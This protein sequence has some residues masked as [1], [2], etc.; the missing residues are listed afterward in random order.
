[1]NINIDKQ[2]N[3]FRRL[4]QDDDPRILKEGEYRYAL[5][6]RVGSSEDGN[7]GLVETI[8]GNSLVSVSL[9]SGTNKVIGSCEDRITNSIF[10]FVW[11]SSGYHTIYRYFVSTNTIVQIFQSSILNFQ[12]SN[13]ISAI[14]VDNMLYWVD[15]YNEAR[16]LN[17][18]Q[19]ILGNS[20]ITAH[21]SLFK[22]GPLFP[23]VVTTSTTMAT[24]KNRTDNKS[25]VIAFRYVYNDNEKSVFSPFSKLAVTSYQDNK[26]D[27]ITIDLTGG[28]KNREF[29]DLYGGPIIYLPKY[30]SVIKGIEVVFRDSPTG[31][32]K[33]L[34][35][36]P[37][38][39]ASTYLTTIFG[40]ITFKNDEIYAIIANSETTKQVDAIPKTPHAIS[41]IKGRLFLA[42]YK[43][44]FD[45][46]ALNVTRNT[47]TYTTYSPTDK[48]KMYLKN[49]CK[50][51]YG[52]VF[53]DEYGRRSGVYTNDQ[54]KVSVDNRYSK[55]YITVKFTLVGQPP[56]WAN[57]YE[58]V[59]TDNLTMSWFCQA[60][61]NDIYYNLKSDP[62]TL[63]PTY[64]Y[65]NYVDQQNTTDSDTSY[66]P[67]KR[68]IEMHINIGNFENQNNKVPYTFTEGDHVSILSIGA[69]LIRGVHVYDSSPASENLR[70]LKIKRTYDTQYGKV[71]VVDYDT[72]SPPYI[73]KG[74]I[75]EIY[76][77]RDNSAPVL[78]YEIGESHEIN[79]PGTPS[80][81]FSQTV[82]QLSTGD[83]HYIQKD[84]VVSA[85]LDQA[86]TE[87]P[88][89][90]IQSM[91]PNRDDIL[92]YWESGLGQPSAIL[93]I[94][95]EV[96][97]TTAIR[98]S[99]EYIQGSNINGLSSFEALNE[100]ILPVEYGPICKLQVSSNNTS[101]TNVMLSVHSK[102]VVS[103]YINEAIFTDVAGKNIVSVTDSVMPSSM[104]MQGSYG[105]VNPESIIQQDSRV[106]GFDI[107]KG[108]V[109]RYSKDGLTPISDIL[110]SNYFYQKSRALLPNLL[111]IKTPATFD[112][113][114]KEY[115]ITLS[116]ETIAFNEPENVWTTY[117]SFVPE[118]YGKAATK[119]VSFK[120]GGLYLHGSNSVY[121]NFYGTQYSSKIK[122]S[123]NMHPSTTK[124]FCN[125]ATEGG[126]WVAISFDTPEGQN[127][128]LLASDYENLENVFYA[129]IMRDINTVGLS[130]FKV[131]IIDGDE[132]R[133][134]YLLTTLENTSTTKAFL[135]AA[136]IGFQPMP[137]AKV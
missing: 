96:Q 8:K 29:T 113:Y 63:A 88:T 42:N 51:Q 71:L 136:D 62:V 34:R 3:I 45:Q 50:Y 22:P 95:R 33:L 72:S 46:Y 7:R 102:E 27:T 44:G 16:K 106:Y 123:T 40:Q 99:N 49:D 17:I 66:R 94:E 109:W 64:V 137:S 53:K 119:M 69:Q 10:Y 1:L 55:E 5:N 76:R 67:A 38:F 12:S 108:V 78:F 30:S 24:N 86:V 118:Y 120:D 116:D 70:N 132:M 100:K 110:N 28:F 131:P 65:G 114:F 103:N 129:T 133:S 25:F 115:I 98:F 39:D 81:A 77:L 85:T 56:A 58:I 112:P 104:A 74:A 47:D 61:C 20:P 84:Y 135:Y 57:S 73:N 80:R 48:N 18:T 13:I 87:T 4:N 19:Q 52:V 125:I 54:L 127:S 36:I 60:R 121:N 134:T 130:G 107:N 111:T 75:V 82:F 41:F 26:K 91:N 37:F 126:L 93:E 35:S 31:P 92:G 9:P 122:L 83:I 14:H 23:P 89:T 101:Q 124:V 79:N 2:K 90:Y 6:C 117:Y 32:F 59:R 68:A 128:S 11:N 21:I 97:K 15:G 43:E 105:S